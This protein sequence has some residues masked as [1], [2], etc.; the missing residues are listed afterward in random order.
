MGALGCVAMALLQDVSDTQHDIH[1]QTIFLG[2]IAFVLLGAAVVALIGGAIMLGIARKAWLMAERVEAKLSPLVD[3]TNG[4]MSELQPKIENITKNVEQ[5]S[6]TVRGKVDELGATLS[7]INRTVKD[8]NDR[9]RV[10]VAHVDGM[11]GDALTTA[12]QVSDTVQENIR[13]P[14][15]QIAGILAGLRVGLET[16]VDRSPFVRRSQKVTDPYEVE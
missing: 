10:H 7:D 13:K 11:V 9:T 2:I 12:Q 8:V 15:R 4:M 3:K 5:V 16:L 6:Y 1:L 14:V